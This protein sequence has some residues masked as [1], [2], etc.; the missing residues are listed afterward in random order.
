MRTMFRVAGVVWLAAAFASCTTQGIYD[1]A[2]R[3]PGT[4]IADGTLQ[5][6]VAQA[7]AMSEMIYSDGCKKPKIVNTDVVE[8][9]ARLNV[10]RWVERW[11]VDRCGTAIYYR[12]ELTPSKG[13]GTDYDVSMIE[14]TRPAGNPDRPQ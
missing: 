8:S 1:G 7:I 12:V 13:G 4:S 9:P 2:T 14:D 6:D 3:V 5:G 11:T 10:D